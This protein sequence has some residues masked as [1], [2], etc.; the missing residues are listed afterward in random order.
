[1]LKLVPTMVVECFSR[2]KSL[3]GTVELGIVEKNHHD[4]N[5]LR[6]LLD[7]QGIAWDKA[8]PVLKSLTPADFKMCSQ[9][10]DKDEVLEEAVLSQLEREIEKAMGKQ[11]PTGEHD[12]VPAPS[13]AVLTSTTA[14]A[15]TSTLK[16]QPPSLV[17]GGSEEA[18]QGL[19]SF[20]GLEDKE[21]L[22]RLL[23][24]GIEAMQDEFILN[25]SLQDL[26]NFFYVRYGIA[27][28][29]AD[30]PAH[31]KDDLQKGK[32]HSGDILPEE[33]DEGNRGKSLK[34]GRAS[35]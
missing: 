33:Y 10:K 19:Y 8:V 13:P 30:M 26:E 1:M 31:F 7:M 14:P 18:A 15:A 9:E 4:M 12:T 21:L 28:N 11:L 17:F 2:G 6:Q 32:Y 24:R 35:E 29:Q 5:N 25:G 16:P 23:G 34:L 3:S 22:A 27:Q 20:I